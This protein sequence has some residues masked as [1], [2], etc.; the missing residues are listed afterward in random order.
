MGSV[1]WKVGTSYQDY[2]LYPEA[3]L[4]NGDWT[5]QVAKNGV[6][7]AATFT[8]ADV[9]NDGRYYVSDNGATGFPAA[10]GVYL[11]SAYKTA[12]PLDKR[13]VT[14]IVNSNGLPSGTMGFVS[15]TAVANNGRIEDDGGTPLEDATV[16]ITRPGGAV[17][18]QLTTDSNGLW[19]PVYFDETG[20]FTATA[21][22][23]GYTSVNFTITVTALTATGPGTDIA[24]TAISS[25]SST[26]LASLIGYARRM[27]VD[28]QGAQATL[29]ITEAINEALKHLCGQR[30]WPWL[31]TTGRLDI[32]GAYGTGTISVTNGSPT[33]TL[34]NGTFP[35][36]AASGDLFIN[37]TW[38]QVQARDDDTT[39]T[40]VDDWFGTSLTDTGY[41][42]AQYRFDLPDNCRTIVN[43]AN[44]QGWLWG[45]EP[46]SRLEIEQMRITAYQASYVPKHAVERNQICIWPYSNTDLMVNL[47]YLRVPATL[48]GGSDVADW[49]SNLLELLYRAIDYHLSIRGECV[50]GDQKKT[51]EAYQDAFKRAIMND[52]TTR[53]RGVGFGISTGRNPPIPIIGNTITGI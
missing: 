31:Y 1:Y 6:S 16:T 37:G 25:A 4:V 8:I 11:L 22:K 29:I 21:E 41:V 26:T 2:I 9:N 34:L 5:K 12:L 50:A 40:M 43:V 39:L 49:D 19:G 53:P 20:V 14:V 13:D 47:L 48:V 33:V 32:T 36:W 44:Q 18:T 3:G 23:P 30:D 38:T 24:L 35:A 42:L 46:V 7:Q 51:F 17:Y 52:K 45:S 15:F 27:F 28:R 10:T